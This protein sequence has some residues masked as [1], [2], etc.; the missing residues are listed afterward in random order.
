M[1][2]NSWGRRAGHNLV[3]E[4]QEQGDLTILF[5]VLRQNFQSQQH[6]HVNVGSF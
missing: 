6:C 5:I 4:Q 2:C 3:T 1:C